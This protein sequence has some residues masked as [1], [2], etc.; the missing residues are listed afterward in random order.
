M[1][2]VIC[3]KWG[4]RYSAEYVNRLYRMVMRNL[5]GDI[6]FV[7]IT[8]D[9][10]GVDK[11]VECKPL[12]HLDV[13]DEIKGKPWLKLMLWDDPLFDIT[14]E[15]L[16]LDLDVVITG[17]LDDFFTYEPG[18]YCVIHNWTHPNRRIGNTSVYRFPIG[19][20][21]YLLENFKADMLGKY[22]KFRA[23]QRYISA[24]INDMVFW[25]SSWCRSFKTELLP[26]VPLRWWRPAPLPEDARVVV[27]HGK[28]DP[29][30][31]LQGRWPVKSGQQWKK[32]YKTIAPAKWIGDYWH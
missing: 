30:E 26:P 10:E 27:F 13:P 7:C 1:K 6:R 22:R 25:P 5:S 4:T 8:D 17:P 18:H 24:E 32:I 14:G 19:K 12:P 31:A 2:N 21:A 11:N 16:F 23:S 29:D 3:M 15:A 9:P 20:H 28:P